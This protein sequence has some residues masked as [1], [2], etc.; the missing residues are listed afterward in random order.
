MIVNLKIRHYDMHAFRSNLNKAL[1]YSYDMDDV[2][3]ADS[4]RI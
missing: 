3:V 1:G 4:G 2:D